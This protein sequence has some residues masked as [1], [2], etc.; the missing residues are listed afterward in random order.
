MNQFIVMGK[1]YSHSNNV[2]GILCKWEVQTIALRL[3]NSNSICG[4]SV[5]DKELLSTEI[6]A[7]TNAMTM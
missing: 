3:F 4:N 6:N 2:C 7:V 5:H 1:S